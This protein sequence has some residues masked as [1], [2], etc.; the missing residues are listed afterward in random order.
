VK[1]QTDP[2]LEIRRNNAEDEA[3][4]DRS[5]YV[6]RFSGRNV[7]TLDPRSCCRTIAI[8]ILA[9]CSVSSMLFA[10]LRPGRRPGLRALT[11]PPRGTNQ[12]ITRCWSS[13]HFENVVFEN[14][15]DAGVAQA[16]VGIITSVPHGTSSVR[17]KGRRSAHPVGAHR[18]RHR[19]QSQTSQTDARRTKAVRRRVY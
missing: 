11:A 4:R 8:S 14:V 7:A 9:P 1:F 13:A 2:L 12:A 15:V 6:P 3:N 18:A 16:Y 17:L 19:A 5:A 10:T